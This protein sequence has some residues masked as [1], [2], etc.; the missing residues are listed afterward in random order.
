MLA[1]TA[2]S[3]NSSSNGSDTPNQNGNRPPT[4]GTAHKKLFRN[5]MRLTQKRLIKYF[6]GLPPQLIWDDQP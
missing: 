4:S 2:E 3:F 6:L 1:F 5:F